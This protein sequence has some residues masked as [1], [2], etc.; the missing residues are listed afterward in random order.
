MIVHTQQDTVEPS[1]ATNP[2]GLMANTI[3]QPKRKSG[4]IMLQNLGEEE[5]LSQIL[6]RE[7]RKEKSAPLQQKTLCAKSK[8]AQ[9]A[10]G[11]TTINA[12]SNLHSVNLSF[13]K[14]TG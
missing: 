14:I 7:A 1:P 2:D 4:R 5:L 13:I 10:S 12:G 3:K 11:E 6:H 9:K 8:D